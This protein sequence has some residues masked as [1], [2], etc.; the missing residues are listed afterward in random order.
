MIK[1]MLKY[2]LISV[3]SILWINGFSQCKDFH[4]SDLC[5]KTNESI[6]GLMLEYSDLSTDFVVN[7]D[8]LEVVFVANPYKIY[9]FIICAK[10]E[11]MPL[12]FKVYDNSTSELIYDNSSEDYKQFFTFMPTSVRNLKVEINITGIKSSDL[13]ECLGFLLYNSN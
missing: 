5:F 11:F 9:H 4:K 6:P 3:L 7:K 13:N 12:T 10:K 2:V 8:K 1:V